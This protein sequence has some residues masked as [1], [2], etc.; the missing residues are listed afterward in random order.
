MQQMRTA[1]RF[2]EPHAASGLLPSNGAGHYG[3]N[4]S[5]G[6][7]GADRGGQGTRGVCPKLT[8][9]DPRE[10]LDGNTRGRKHAKISVASRM[11]LHEVGLQIESDSRVNF[12]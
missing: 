1:A 5:R 8:I 4:G 3:G 12:P 11:S 10:H 7:T 2:N 6:A 9:E